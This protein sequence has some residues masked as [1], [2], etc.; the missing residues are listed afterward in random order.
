VPS[1]VLGYVHHVLQYEQAPWNITSSS[2]M[3]RDFSDEPRQSAGRGGDLSPSIPGSPTSRRTCSGRQSVASTM[4][5]WPSWA[6]AASWPR[7][8]ISFVIPRAASALSW[9]SRMR[10]GPTRPPGSSF[11]RR[12]TPG[13]GRSRRGRRPRSGCGTWAGSIDQ[14]SRCVCCQR[15][16][17]RTR[18]LREGFL[19]TMA[20]LVW[21]RC[22]TSG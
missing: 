10:P 6:I 16:R 8:W 13:R 19:M 18:R 7:S 15:R 14:C 12:R 3:R 1:P 4:A 21:I 20:H 2:S 11:R 22:H 9:T 5:S 17:T